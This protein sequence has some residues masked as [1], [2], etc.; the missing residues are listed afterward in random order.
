MG[1]SSISELSYICFG[2][3]SVFMINF[4]IAFVIFG[5]LTLYMLLFSRI[6]ISL[7]EP[8]VVDPKSFL[9]NKVTY[10]VLVSIL[11]FPLL[12]KRNLTELK[13][14][15]HILCA[16]VITL[17]MILTVKQF[18]IEHHLEKPISVEPKEQ[19]FF[20]ER[21]VDSV[22]I[23]LTS[24]GFVINLFPISNQLETRTNSNMLK[25][26]VLALGFCFGAYFC[27]TGLCINIYGEQN[28]K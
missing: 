27:L 4:L 28:I 3:A 13:F 20:M 26:V 1:F 10:I 11:T 8:Y 17:L 19:D 9:L 25:S 15:S 24:Y 14:Q 2:R 7:V 5:I 22:N 23:L 6:A 21:I 12:I 18:Q 16:G